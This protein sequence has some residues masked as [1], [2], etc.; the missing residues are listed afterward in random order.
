MEKIRWG[1]IGA[2]KIARTFAEAINGT[3]DAEF[4]AVA[5]RNRQ[6][7]EAF[8]SKTVQLRHTA[9]IRNLLRTKM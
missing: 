1:I 4:Y 3:E 7:A 2:G 8:A 6:K 9:V 5:S